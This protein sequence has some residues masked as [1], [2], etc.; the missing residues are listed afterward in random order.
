VTARKTD[1]KNHIIAAAI[2]VHNNIDLKEPRNK[3][4]KTKK[5]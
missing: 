4:K 5:N 1:G 3:K 2:L